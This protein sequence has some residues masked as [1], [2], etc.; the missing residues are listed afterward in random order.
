[1]RAIFLPVWS[2]GILNRVYKWIPGTHPSGGWFDREPL[3]YPHGLFSYVDW[4]SHKERLSFPEGS[5]IFG[6]SG[7]FT[8]ISKPGEV[9]DPVEVLQWQDAT[10]SV[11]A[12]LDRPPRRVKIRDWKGCLDFTISNVE[13]ALPYYLKRLDAGTAFRWWGVLHGNDE[14]ES[15]EWYNALTKVYPFSADGEGWAVYP[16]P[17]AHPFT[18]ARAMRV[19]QQLGIKRAHFLAC[20][21]QDV[22]ATILA[23]G[24]MAGLDLV[25]F[26]SMSHAVASINRWW[27]TTD[28]NLGGRSGRSYETKNQA[29]RE[30]NPQGLLAAAALPLP[31][32]DP[33]EEEVIV[34]TGRK[35]H[36][37]VDYVFENVRCLDDLPERFCRECSCPVC[38]YLRRVTPQFLVNSPGGWRDAAITM[39]NIHVQK[40]CIDR[41]AVAAAADPKE[42]LEIALDPVTAARTFRI[43]RGEES[44]RPVSTGSNLG[45]FS[46]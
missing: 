1:M 36:K 10:V 20:T 4:R 22:I 8:L 41:Q 19:L 14:K 18:V 5:Y 7:G 39:H 17:Q 45:L 29:P 40:T 28:P 33:R 44:D 31:I 27:F 35:I 46:K 23:L 34:E 32:V 15:Y 2:T 25:T 30:F 43:F 42:F 24:P 38:Q 6:D 16:G 11:G 26:D 3:R 13:R 21:G 9:L 12:I 37:D